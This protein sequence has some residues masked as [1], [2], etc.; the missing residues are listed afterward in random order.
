[1]HSPFFLYVEVT[2]F[3]EINPIRILVFPQ[4]HE[5]EC[6]FCERWK[7]YVQCP[8]VE[9][10]FF[11]FTLPEKMTYPR[12]ERGGYLKLFSH[13]L[14]KGT[15][16][17]CEQEGHTVCSSSLHDVCRFTGLCSPDPQSVADYLFSDR[18]FQTD[19]SRTLIQGVQQIPAAHCFHISP[20]RKMLLPYWEPQKD[21]ENRTFSF[22]KAAHELEKAFYT[23]MEKELAP[24]TTIGCFYSGGV[25]SSSVAGFAQEVFRSWDRNPVLLFSANKAL[26]TKEEC[27]LREAFARSMKL[28]LYECFIDTTQSIVPLLREAN[29]YTSFPSGG[30]FAGVNQHL[31]REALRYGV[32]LFFDGVG[33]EELF[34]E[35]D[36]LLYDLLAQGQWQAAYRC[37]GYLTSVNQD[38]KSNVL[39]SVIEPYT[40]M[41][42]KNS[43]KHLFEKNLAS[44]YE[45]LK[46]DVY[47]PLY[48]KKY[49]DE[50]DAFHRREQSLFKQKRDEGWLFNDYW[51]FVQMCNINRHERH[52]VVDGKHIPTFSPLASEEM[53]RLAL[54]LRLEDRIPTGTGFRSKPLLRTVASRI[55][56]SPLINHPK[57]NIDDLP[58]R[59]LKHTSEEI[60][61]LLSSPHLTTLGIQPEITRDDLLGDPLFGQLPM[62]LL[63]VYVIW[64]EELVKDVKNAEYSFNA[65][66]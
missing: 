45:S 1:M 21:G 12:F 32:D 37:L 58:G 51:M 40:M 56:P 65:S 3:S 17:L 33:G 55:I 42:K 13:P 8:L 46:Q 7:K 16:Y 39:A 60:L 24:Y 54:K 34:G 20:E 57:I 66:V 63:A 31:T 38:W 14:G 47:T 62:I 61:E 22:Q 9:D 44:Y 4:N 53:F 64:M 52:T 6:S 41:G 30:L 35:Y 43:I 10:T 59:I 26:S 18:K 29:K 23:V 36:T 48:G 11:L 27:L 15:F 49:A 28:S 25:D 50:F 19:P 2:M 5:K